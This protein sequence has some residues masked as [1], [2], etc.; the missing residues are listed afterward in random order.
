MKV[1]IPADAKCFLISLSVPYQLKFGVECPIL[2]ECTE[3]VG[4]QDI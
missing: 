3:A 2:G 4:E 1:S